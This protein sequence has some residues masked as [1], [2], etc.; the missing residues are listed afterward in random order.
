MIK[1]II[2]DDQD[3]VCQ[4]LRAILSAVESIDVVGIA[5]NGLD[6]L[7]LLTRG[8]VDIALMDLKMPIMNGIQA[9]REIK[10]KYPRTRVLVLTTYDA[11]EWVFDAIRA[12]ADG[13]L[14]KDASREKLLQAINEIIAGDTPVDAKVAG[15]L[16]KQIAKNPL[17]GPS[18]LALDLSE[19][20]TEV[21][22]LLAAGRT[23]AEI[24]RLLFLSE[25]TVRNYVSAVLEK[26]N[27]QDR[28]QAALLAIRHGLVD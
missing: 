11:D 9:T 26:L 1:I 19:R 25:G 20:E 22:R 2:V 15:R 10:Q 14:L 8:D 17:Q 28:T 3:V 21:L 18:N 16:L 5:N 24:A 13:Y 4:G 27:V 7:D 23:N 12:G 6:A